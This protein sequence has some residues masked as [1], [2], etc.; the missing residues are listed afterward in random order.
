LSAL[1]F[2]IVLQ[3]LHN[4]TKLIVHT[5]GVAMFKSMVS[6][7]REEWGELFFWKVT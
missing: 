7:I 3:Q 2:F 6:G 4:E 5:F 1:L